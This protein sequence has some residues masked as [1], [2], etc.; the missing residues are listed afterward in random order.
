M[1]KLSAVIFDMDGLMVDSEPVAR[2]GWQ[3]ALAEHGRALAEDVFLQLLGRTTEGTRAILVQAYGAGLPF[4]SMLQHKRQYVQDEI[5]RHGVAI[6]PGL[7]ELLAWLEARRTAKA[8]ASSA[9]REDVMHKLTRTGLAGRFEAIVTGDQVTNGKPAPDIFLEA[10][11]QLGAPAR[12]CAVL[13][14]SDAGI[15]A[16]QAAGM[17][18]LMVPDIKP[19]SPESA[20]LAHRIFPTLHEV[21][22]FL[23]AEARG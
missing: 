16:A 20:R 8:V 14:D 12:E 9:R 18:P 11:R 2:I 17:L 23:E 3:R 21:R 5:A 22:A 6:K 4:E 15:Q 19:P 13:E 7:P 1:F 10:A